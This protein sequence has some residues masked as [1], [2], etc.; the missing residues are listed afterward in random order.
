M[1]A[2][3][4][5]TLSLAAVMAAGVFAGCSNANA[6]TIKI[7]GLAPLTGN[8]SVYGITSSNGTKLAFDEINKNGGILGKTVDFDLQDEKGEP[9]EAINAYNKLASSGIVALIG[10]VTS[11]P[12]LAVGD[13]IAAESDPTPML[14][15]TGTADA[16]TKAGDSIFR[17]CFTDPTQGQIIAKFAVDNLKIKTVAILSNVSDEYSNGL[18]EAFTSVVKEAGVE[19]IANEGYGADDKD[20][21]TQLTKIQ[22]LNPD[23]LFIPD[24]YNVVALVAQ[25]AREVGYEGTLLGGDGWDGIL[26]TLPEDKKTVVDNCYYASHFSTSDTTPVVANFV[27]SYQ[28]KY[29]ELPTSFSA[30]GY[31][32][33]YIMKAAIEKAGSTDKAKIVEALKGVS[34]ECVTGNI[35]FDEN[36]DPIKDV[37]IIKLSNGEASLETKITME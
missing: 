14:T 11:K 24:Y 5:L 36:G 27:K 3:K 26:G 28:E 9:N 37:A 35:T 34:V 25:Q 32:A 7:G 10:D 33:A 31:D 23:A 1:K 19:I 29:N 12:S 13:I 15:P 2:K 30:L 18:A 20:F 4:I 22:G 21:K 17:V 16:I 8:V 6:D